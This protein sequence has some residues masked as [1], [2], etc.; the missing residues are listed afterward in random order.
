MKHQPMRQG[1]TTT[2]RT[3]GNEVADKGGEHL[4]TLLAKFIL[5]M[6]Y[7]SEMKKQFNSQTAIICLILSEVDKS[8]SYKTSV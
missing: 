1:Q 5:G 4:T 8:S 6:N 3:I 7:P 2:L